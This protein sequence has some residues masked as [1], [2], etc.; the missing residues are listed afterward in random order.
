MIKTTPPGEVRLWNKAPGKL[1][2]PYKMLFNRLHADLKTL[3]D[4]KDFIHEL[5]GEGYFAACALLQELTDIR[6]EAD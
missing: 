5:S 3:I 6:G 4:D 1:S 2:A